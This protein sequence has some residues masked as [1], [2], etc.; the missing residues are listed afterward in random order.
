MTGVRAFFALPLREAELGSLLDAQA[1]MRGAARDVRS[2][3][4][5][6][7]PAQL[8]LTLKFLGEVRREGLSTLRAAT[9]TIAPATPALAARTLGLTAFG[10]PRRA[11]VVVVKL[12]DPK[13]S[14]SALASALEDVAEALGVARESRAFT[15]HVTL[16]RLKP[17]GDAAPL[18][19]AATLAPAT[20]HFDELVLFES[21]LSSEGA[22]YSALERAAL[23]TA[24]PPGEDPPTAR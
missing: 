12:D 21:T 14:L 1:G 4:R 7:K 13:G 24:S 11:G 15:P 6:T 19:S 3:V 20:L 18:L 22:R 17:P 2:A 9:R 10:K 16:A 8:H 5:F 23:S